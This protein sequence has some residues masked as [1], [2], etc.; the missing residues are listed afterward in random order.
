MTVKEAIEKQIIEEV[1]KDRWDDEIISETEL[2]MAAQKFG[3]RIPILTQSEVYLIHKE[4]GFRRE[5]H[6]RQ[7]R[8]RH[9]STRNQS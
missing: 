5:R 8:N 4:S 3:L 2:L 6:G 7:N 9:T 1:G